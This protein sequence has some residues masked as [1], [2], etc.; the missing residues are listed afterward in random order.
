MMHG[1]M[2]V[3]AQREIAELQLR[4]HRIAQNTA[5]QISAIA[6]ADTARRS[7]TDMRRMEGCTVAGG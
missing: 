6:T 4:G 1:R 7:I 2:A 3:V 5:S